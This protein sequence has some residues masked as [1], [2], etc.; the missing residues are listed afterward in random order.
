MELMMNSTIN[1]EKESYPVY[2]DFLALPFLALFFPSVRFFLDRFIFEK[3]ARRVI[4]GPGFQKI[5]IEKD[6][7]RRKKVYKFK[8]SAWKLVYY[9]SAE[10]LALAVTYNEPWFLN[11]RKFWH[12][13][14]KISNRLYMYAGGFCA[15]SIFALMFWET[16]RKDFGVT[17]VHHV[18]T[19][20]LIVLSY[21]L[22]FGRVGSVVLA[23]HDGSDVFLE[24]AK[25]SKYGGFDKMAD[26]AFRLFALSW[27]AL[28]ILFYPLWILRST[29]YEVLQMF[30]HDKHP[31][32]GPIYYYVFNTLIFCLYVLH[33]YW[34]V[35]IYRMV[36]AQ[37]KA[38]GRVSDDVRSDSEG[39]ENEHED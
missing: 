30:D 32:E 22:R 4:L 17:M 38:K 31:V 9:L 24:V 14:P 18:A 27:V 2:Q 35:L 25:M 33:I 29:S 10:F 19:L 16:R 26:A 13:L 7:D 36:E 1:W 6:D 23:L 39:E 5:D 15:Y 34:W 21:I 28:R 12:P 37:Y 11:T 3:L 20:I 8:E